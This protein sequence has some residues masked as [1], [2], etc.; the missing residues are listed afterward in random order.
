MDI[1][2][3]LWAV[4]WFMIG[5]GVTTPCYRSVMKKRIMIAGKYCWQL[6][7]DGV[8]WE[9]TEQSLKGVVDQL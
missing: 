4:W 8:S 1:E 3:I 6:G 7:Q 5:V 2:S 9:L